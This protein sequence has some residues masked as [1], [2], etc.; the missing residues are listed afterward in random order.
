VSNAWVQKFQTPGYIFGAWHK[1]R[2]NGILCACLTD[3]RDCIAW[4]NDTI[5]RYTL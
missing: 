2:Y 4:F 5:R 1:H 3:H